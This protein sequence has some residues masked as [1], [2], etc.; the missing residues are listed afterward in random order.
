MMWGRF[1]QKVFF[2]LVSCTFVGVT[3]RMCM[4]SGWGSFTGRL[5]LIHEPTAPSLPKG[6]FRT[7]NS[8]ALEAVVFPP[9]S[10]NITRRNFFFCR[11]IFVEPP[12]KA[13]IALPAK[14]WGI[15]RPKSPEGEILAIHSPTWA[16][17]AAKIWFRRFSSFNFQEKWAQEISR[18]ILN[19]FHEQWNK[20]LS[21]RDSGSLGPQ[22]FISVKLPKKTVILE[23]HCTTKGLP[24]KFLGQ[25]I[26]TCQPAPKYHTKGCSRSSADSPG[27]RTL[28]FATFEPFS[29][30]EFRTSIARTPFCAIL[31]RSPNL[32]TRFLAINYND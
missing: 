31:W 22:E 1:I 2:A 4:K 18:K 3:L 27:A 11:A 29:S 14:F 9:P 13:V 16:K 23:W 15:L 19:K 7:E 24:C 32:V 17:N 5:A 26:S 30:C 8:M 20:I 6:P 25:L 10:R 21:P 28:V 12:E